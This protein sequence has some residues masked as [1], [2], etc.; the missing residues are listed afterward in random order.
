MTY[1]SYCQVLQIVSINNNLLSLFPINHFKGDLLRNAA[2]ILDIVFDIDTDLLSK[3]SSSSELMNGI[4]EALDECK[5]D[6]DT[7]SRL[8]CILQSYTTTENGIASLSK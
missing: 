2:A 3:W 6:T 1:P 8:M 7:T 4:C 5:N